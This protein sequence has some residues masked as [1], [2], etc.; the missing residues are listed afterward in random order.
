[1]ERVV[2]QLMKT[3]NTLAQTNLVIDNIIYNNE[4]DH[5][6]LCLLFKL[7]AKVL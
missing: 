5:T 6:F 2:E 4:A 1:M 3:P 7:I